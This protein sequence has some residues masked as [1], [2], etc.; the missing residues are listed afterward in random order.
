MGG[1][2]VQKMAK[3]YDSMLELA[4][5][6]PLLRLHHMEKEIGGR[7]ELVAKLEFI[8]PT[9][10]IKDR[11]AGAWIEW[12]EQDGGLRPGTGVIAAAEK[13]T[14]V[15]LALAAAVKG[16]PLTLIMPSRTRIE[17]RKLVCGYGAK[18]V[19]VP[20]EIEAAREKAKAIAGQNT[21]D[22]LLEPAGQG[23]SPDTHGDTLGV[24][25]WN[26]TDGRVDL[27]VADT[28]TWGDLVQTAGYLKEKNPACRMVAAAVQNAVH[29]QKETGMIDETIVVSEDEARQ[30]TAAIA[31]KEG[32]LVG[33]A[34]GAA[35]MAA[36]HVA[37]RKE[38]AGKRICV[39]LAD[40]GERY[41]STEVFGA[42]LTPPEPF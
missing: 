27:V 20:G 5:A 39:I 25:L 22:F 35:V 6:T 17:I 36:L 34:S 13:N 16:H 2:E 30:T 15:G 10:S 32:I 8:N 40:T 37:G 23:K 21:K 31:E 9:R 28:E 7:A 41:L 12:A 1:K 38:N 4:G 3:V 29:I 26:D 42:V 19:L 14:G 33:I 18:L 24:E 11:M